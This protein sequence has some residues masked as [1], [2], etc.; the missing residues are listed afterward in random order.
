[1]V[2]NA[3]MDYPVYKELDHVILLLMALNIIITASAAAASKEEELHVVGTIDILLRMCLHHDLD[4]REKNAL[5]SYYHSSP[6]LG[7]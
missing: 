6:L 3:N 7:E 4:E 5:Y 1:M 2:P